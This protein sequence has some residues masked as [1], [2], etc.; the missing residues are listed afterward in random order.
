M[1]TAARDATPLVCCLQSGPECPTIDEPTG[2]ASGRV[3]SVVGDDDDAGQSPSCFTAYYVKWIESGGARAAVIPYDVNAT[4]LAALLV[5]V[6]AGAQRP[7]GD[8][9]AQGSLNGALFTG[10]GLSLD[11]NTT[12]YASAKAIFDYTVAVNT[13]G[14]GGEGLVCSC[15]GRRR[16][17]RR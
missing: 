17:L 6:P 14:E 7:R 4:V 9:S 3:R 8:V 13:A 10:G 2:G 5:R 15:W 1:R 12:Y 11:M 16:V